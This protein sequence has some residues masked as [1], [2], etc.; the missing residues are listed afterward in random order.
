M[1]LAGCIAL[2]AFSAVAKA[3][4]PPGLFSQLPNTSIAKL[5]RQAIAGKSRAVKINRDLLNSDRIFV[6]LPGNISFEAVRGK[7]QN[8][9]KGRFAWVGHASDDPRDTVVIS[10]SGNAVAGTFVRHGKLFKL[11]PRADGSQVLSEVKTT[12]PAPEHDP[13][14]VPDTTSSAPGSTAS[15]SVAEN[16]NG[17]VLDVLV[18]YTPAVQALYGTDGT[19]AL[20][21]QAVAEAN[22]AYGNSN[23]T[24][25]L[26][27][28]HSVMT[29]YTESGDMG[30]DL[31]RLSATNDGF[32]DELPRARD[33]YGADLVSL[34][35]ADAQYC[36]IGYLM[37]TLS[38]SSAPWAFS[39]VSHA[40]A[41]GYYSFAHEIGHNQ[42]AHHDLAN[43]GGATTI[44]PYAHGYQA[45]NSAFR[46]VMAYNCP[47][48]C[49]RIQ[50]FANPNVLYNGLPTGEPTYAADA[51]AID[52]TAATVAAFREHVVTEVPP[53]C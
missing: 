49:T 12:D 2:L 15:G 36:G 10:V 16:I 40:C 25:R 21:L 7:Y 11:E 30:T 22:E 23:M 29:N 20:I 3:P 31:G 9:G 13:V 1:A 44:Y 14:P 17:S 19:D 26:N 46:T 53:G 32:M 43:A 18:A 48:G 51:I 33:A 50:H 27:L 4:E 8:M 28:V 42:G 37:T 24:T 52:Q 35:E 38:A 6:S 34:L 47:G 41:T 45:P 39:V 5:P